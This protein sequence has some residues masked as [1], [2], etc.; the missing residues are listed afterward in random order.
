MTSCSN[1]NEQVGNKGSY[2]PIH[3]FFS[4]EVDSLKTKGP[5]VSKTV[6]KGSDRE[7]KEVQITNWENEMGAFLSVDLSKPAY[8]GMYS[9]DSTDN[10]ITYTAH[11]A[12]VDISSIYIEF[13]EQGQVDSI[14]IIKSADNILY[15]NKEKLTYKRGLSYSLTK[16]QNIL[17]LGNRIYH[18]VGEIR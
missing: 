10:S 14:E 16:D 7:T 5:I 13:D 9:I 1:K 15:Q 4:Q 18:I 11:S 8:E 12:E 2:Y 17:M 6:G 3:D